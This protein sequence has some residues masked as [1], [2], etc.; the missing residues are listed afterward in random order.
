M[1]GPWTPSSSGAAVWSVEA[2]AAA[3]AAACWARACLW[4]RARCEELERYRE[5]RLL[6]RGLLERAGGG[7]VGATGAARPE[8]E[9]VSA[10]SGS[11]GGGSYRSK[12]NNS[13]VSCWTKQD[14]SDGE[15]VFIPTDHH[16]GSPSGADAH[17]WRV[18]SRGV[19]CS[20]RGVHTL[21]LRV[22]RCHPSPSFLR[23]VQRLQTRQTQFTGPS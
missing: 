7:L 17:G 12:R 11:M 21:I 2:M 8:A 6:D 16:V 5:M 4:R 10:F 18:S 15:R 1:N 19:H 9:D 23:G 20:V 14:G 3:A 22:L 13:E